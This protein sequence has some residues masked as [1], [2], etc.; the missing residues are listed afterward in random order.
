MSGNTLFENTFDVEKIDE[1][2]Y[3]GKVPLKMPLKMARGVYGGHTCAQTLLVAIRSAPG[4]IP[5][6]LHSYFLAPGNSNVPMRYKVMKLLDSRNFAIRYI[7]VH[8]NDRIRYTCTVSL[9]RPG[10]RNNPKSKYDIR[11]PFP[12]KID[13]NASTSKV[14]HHTGYILTSYNDKFL[15]YKLVPEEVEKH[16]TQRNLVFHHKINQDD[17]F[18][19]RAYNYVA[20]ADISDSALLTTLARVLHIPWNPTKDHPYLEYQEERTALF[21]LDLSINALHIYHYNAMSLD[22]HI[23][24]H[25]DDFE[26]FDPCASWLTS[27]VRYKRHSNNRTVVESSMYNSDGVCV[28]TVV[29]EGLVVFHQGI[30]ELAK[31]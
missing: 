5:H 8:Q 31:I 10:R 9:V 1:E 12:G 4:L 13:R 23:Y 29:Q 30:P 26:S 22:H 21:A 24:F 6:S 11:D 25:M 18:S 2:N 19:D 14:Q 3:V 17:P 28:A 15:D 16:P 7:E 27:D 20:L